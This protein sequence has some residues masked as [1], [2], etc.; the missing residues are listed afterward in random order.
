MID[1][2]IDVIVDDGIDACLPNQESIEFAVRLTCKTATNN[3]VTPLV[4]IRFAHDNAVQELNAQWRNKDKVT[5]VLS[6]P[7]QEG[8]IYAASEPLGDIILAMPFVL[9][10]ARR[11]Q[12]ETHAHI[13]HLI[14]HGMLHLLGH[15]HIHDNDAR[16]MQR[17]ESQI[18]KE[19][20]LHPPYPDEI[21]DHV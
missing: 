17:L 1:A 4:C 20:H 16:I 14:I 3:I 18:M 13:L 11:L 15:D 7:M 12:H 21:S 10:E 6:F 19:L 5:D 2:A 8:D 9:H